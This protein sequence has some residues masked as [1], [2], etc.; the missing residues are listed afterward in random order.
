MRP[1][2]R[3]MTLCD[4]AVILALLAVAVAG[5][6]RLAT[7]PRGGRIV[8]T[9][10]VRTVY[11]APLGIPRSVELAGPL[12]R[13]R[14]EIDDSGARIVTAP[15]PRKVCMTMG[16]VRRTGELIACIPNRILVRVDAPANEEAPFDL[17]SR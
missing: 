4:G 16:P 2:W 15:C 9:D 11:T 1:P 7:A 17:I 5:V 8:V 10:G 3:F 12:G 6:A 14:L 13:S